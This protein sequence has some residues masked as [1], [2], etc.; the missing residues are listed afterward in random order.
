[1]FQH[2]KV[3]FNFHLHELLSGQCPSLRFSL[4]LSS[5]S[6][7]L[8]SLELTPTVKL[9]VCVSACIVIHPFCAGMGFS[10]GPSINKTFFFSEASSTFCFWREAF[11]GDLLCLRR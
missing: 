4:S 5:L 11:F 1:M 3:F 2:Y 6:L 8:R 10:L 9:R 7:A